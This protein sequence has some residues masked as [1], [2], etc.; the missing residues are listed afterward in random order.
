MDSGKANE[1]YQKKI[2]DSDNENTGVTMPNASINFY[3]QSYVNH[4]YDLH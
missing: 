2:K 4:E 1:N 3:I